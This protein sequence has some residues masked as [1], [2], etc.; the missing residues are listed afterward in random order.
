MT[1]DEILAAAQELA[2]SKAPFVFATVDA[3]G[4]PQVRWMGG[5][6]LDEPF[7]V[8][9]MSGAQARKLAQ[10]R[11]N[12]AGQLVFSTPD[13]SRVITVSGTCEV[14]EDLECKE[15]MW[16]AMPE[17]AQFVSGPEDPNFG[18]VRFTGRRLELLAVME[19]GPEP[20]VAEL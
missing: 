5:L 20:L 2:R 17:L 19:L 3:Q 18:L 10:I 7:Q 4:A 16:A 1:H 6:V 11:N 9:M 14:S 15:R 8:C 12:P 13:F